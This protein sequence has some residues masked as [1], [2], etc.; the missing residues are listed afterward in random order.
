MTPEARARW[1]A[2]RVKHGAYAGNK[3]SSEHAIWRGMHARCSRPTAKD[4]A[5]YG[6]R[7]VS[8]CSEWSDFETFLRDMGPR[9][10][11]A[12]SLDREDNDGPY[13]PGNCRWA[14]RS[15]QQSNK[16][17]T[18]RWTFQGRTM[19]E[20]HWAAELGISKELANYRGRHWGGLTQEAGWQPQNT[21]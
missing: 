16:R 1:M 9:P 7:G 3:E 11:P 5:R 21:Q 2:A 15:E 4:Y 10:S 13:S 12:H 20:S 19:C 6:G 18:K 8:V 14:T 17:N